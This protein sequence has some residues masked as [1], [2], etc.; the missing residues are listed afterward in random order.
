MPKKKSE[1]A[2]VVHFNEVKINK[3]VPKSLAVISPPA[4]KS[5]APNII[6]VAVTKPVEPKQATSTF[7]LKHVEKVK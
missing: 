3:K 1:S 6:P 5:S 7:N 2:R 4:P